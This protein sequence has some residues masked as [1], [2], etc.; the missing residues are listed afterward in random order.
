M[1]LASRLTKGKIKQ[2][3]EGKDFG[4][5]FDSKIVRCISISDGKVLYGN[6]LNLHDGESNLIPRME[7]ALK[8]LATF[9]ETKKETF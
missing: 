7:K 3:E 4:V 1:V 2:R 9:C 5:W 8:H 6:H